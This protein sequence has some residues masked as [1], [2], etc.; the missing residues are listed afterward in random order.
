M[1]HQTEPKSNAKGGCPSLP[2]EVKTT[3][4]DC[5]I[6]EQQE[7]SYVELLDGGYDEAR[8]EELYTD[9]TS[10]VKERG[11]W[12]ASPTSIHP[13]GISFQR[14]TLKVNS[15]LRLQGFWFPPFP[16]YKGTFDS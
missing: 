2:D 5:S 16:S 6:A 4:L 14:S 15:N 8:F 12:H 1:V 13:D 3:K 9:V 10:T 11:I 7:E